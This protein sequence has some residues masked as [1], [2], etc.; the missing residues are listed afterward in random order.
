MFTRTNNLINRDK[1]RESCFIIIIIF[2]LTMISKDLN[3]SNNSKEM[4]HFNTIITISKPLFDYVSRWYL[5][6]MAH[7]ILSNYDVTN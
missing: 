2:R 1:I 5:L 7:T 3:S 6:H 4:Y